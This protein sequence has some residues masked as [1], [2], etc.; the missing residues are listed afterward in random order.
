MLIVDRLPGT[1]R[2]LYTATDGSYLAELIGIAGG[3]IAIPPVEHG[4]K[5]LSKEDL[6]A[7]DPDNILDFIQGPKRPLRGRSDGGHGRKCRSSKPCA[8]I[9]STA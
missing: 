6:L 9:A 5:K 2:D 1:L 8:R 7:A 3:R 4:Y